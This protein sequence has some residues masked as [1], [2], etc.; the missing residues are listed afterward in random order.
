MHRSTSF[1]VSLAPGLLT[2]SSVQANSHVS[3]GIGKPVLHQ[4]STALHASSTV[5]SYRSALPI[6]LLHLQ[7]SILPRSWPE[8]SLYALFA[9]TTAVRLSFNSI[10]VT[11]LSTAAQ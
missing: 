5:I 1:S 10:V 11:Q 6:L 4:G 3:S 2:V 8:H 7:F 9:V